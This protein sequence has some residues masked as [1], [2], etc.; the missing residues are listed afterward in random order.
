MEYQFQT[1]YICRKG[2][3]NGTE[4]AVYLDTFKFAVHLECIEN[5]SSDDENEE[6]QANIQHGQ[7]VCQ[8][9][10]KHIILE[11]N[12][13]KKMHNEAL[14]NAGNKPQYGQSEQSV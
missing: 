12:T 14:T 3:P 1:C 8:Q 13:L 10:T 9:I 7:A 6:R 5:G 11:V 4:P 2:R